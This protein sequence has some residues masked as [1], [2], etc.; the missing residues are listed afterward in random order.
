MSEEYKL[1]SNYYKSFSGTDTLVFILM[2]GSN[3]VVLGSITTVSYSA[4]RTKQPVINLGR[5]YMNGMTRGTRIYAGTMIFTLI[6]QHWLNEL[7]ETENLKW[8]KG[9]KD[10][11]ADELPLFDLMIVSANE[12]GSYVS[13]FIY[14]VDITDEGQVISVEDLFTENTLSFVARDI[15]AFK[16]GTVVGT[17]KTVSTSDDNAVINKVDISGVYI[18]DGTNPDEEYN[19]SLPQIGKIV[20][21]AKKVVLELKEKL[22]NF[23][24]E[25]QYIPG[26]IMVGDDVGFIQEKLG[27][28][29]NY[30]Y[31]GDTE[32]A[33]KEYQSKHGFDNITGV[34]DSIT[35]LSI[36]NNEDSSTPT[37]AVIN[38]SGTRVYSYPNIN[39][40]IVDILPYNTVMEI[41]NKVQEK[42]F[43]G[44][45]PIL[46]SINNFYQIEQGYVNVNDIFSYEY[47]NKDITFPTINMN[48]TGPYVTLLQ[49]LL[50]K[51]Y[52]EFEHESGIYDEN[53]RSLIEKIQ[54][55][56]NIACVLGIVNEDTWRV[57]QNLTGTTITDISNKEVYVKSGNAQGE[58]NL[59]SVDLD[60]ELFKGF[61][62]EIIPNKNI[63]AQCCAIAYYDEDTKIMNK[64]YNIKALETKKIPFDTFKKLFIY[65]ITNEGYP[66]K[67]EYLVYLY[68]GESYKWII[69]YRGEQ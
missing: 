40:S 13:M 8:L 43:T 50:T 29:V 26:D 51:V 42:A 16:A 3:P 61:D 15:Q 48:E 67:V 20:E 1:I 19:A 18:T 66:N 63:T 69:N 57:L 49:E 33:V 62:L 21:N 23:R 34:V 27:I 68:N 37:G 53:T 56:N 14:G 60:T 31:D 25:L 12:Y 35:Y 54:K 41:H 11:K 55:E 30:M 38:E 64:G 5:T 45:T 2:P 65:D 32:K 9:Y 44:D 52:G 7:A 22:K 47:S 10:L 39:A 59:T 17:N 24:R 4:Y 58:Y 46:N 36:L 28:T 6:N